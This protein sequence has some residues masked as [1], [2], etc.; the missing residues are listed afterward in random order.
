MML[1]YLCRVGSATNILWMGVFPTEG[2]S[3]WV[4]L[5]P[6]FIEMSVLNANSVYPEQGLS[7]LKMSL[8]RDTKYKW[9]NATTSIIT[10][11]FD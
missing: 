5:L 3:G 11:R 1:T 6:W 4:L 8:L 10:R 2:V 9:V 7:C